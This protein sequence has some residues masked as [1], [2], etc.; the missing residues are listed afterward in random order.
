MPT[1]P[2]TLRRCK[3]RFS[4]LALSQNDY[5]PM[6]QV[7]GIVRRC[8]DLVSWPALPQNVPPVSSILETFRRVKNA[9]NP[10]LRVERAAR[11]V[12][13]AARS[14]YDCARRSTHDCC[15]AF[16][17]GGPQF[18]YLGNVKRIDS[19][20]PPSRS[21]ENKKLRIDSRGSHSR[22]MCRTGRGSC[23]PRCS[24]PHS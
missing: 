19:R 21:L 1:S 16:A 5:E 24:R 23:C 7:I 12:G 3:D 13:A 2:G 14:S 9:L 17:E 22:R 15:L 18:H 10:E 6:C 11:D 20:G 8:K 4:W